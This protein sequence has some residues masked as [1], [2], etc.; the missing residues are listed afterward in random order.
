MT[1]GDFAALVAE[2]RAAQRE[3]HNPKTRTEN[4]IGKAITLERRVDLAL[5]ELAAGPQPAGLFDEEAS[6]P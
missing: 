6:R 5:K 3:F 2:M 4:S 1:L